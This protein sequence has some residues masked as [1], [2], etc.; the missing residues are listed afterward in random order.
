ML[1]KVL[2]I[3]QQKGFCKFTLLKILSIEDPKE[4]RCEVYH[5]YELKIDE[6]RS[7]FEVYTLE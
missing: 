1:G 6:Y 3:N 7:F 2:I 4:Q 5:L